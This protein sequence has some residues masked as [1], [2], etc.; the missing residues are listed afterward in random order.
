MDTV[1]QL[2]RLTKSYHQRG[3]TPATSSN[4]SIRSSLDTLLI[5][6]SGRHKGMLQQPDFMKMTVSGDIIDQGQPSAETGL[7]LMLYQAAPKVQAVLHTHSAKATTLSMIHESE[8]LL[9]SDYEI[10]KAFPD[11]DTHATA[12]ELKIFNNSQDIP[13]LVE[14]ITPSLESLQLPA[15]LIRGHG[16]YAWGE[17]LADADRHLEAIEYLIECDILRRQLK[18]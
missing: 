3:W 18:S 10:L 11:I 13:Q 15:F 6:R 5:T 14:Q 17:S 12:I 9:F 2:I 8:H 1:E 4:F 7:H 16:I